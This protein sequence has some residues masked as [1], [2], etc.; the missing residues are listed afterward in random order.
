MDQVSNPLRH[1]HAVSN[2]VV[3]SDILSSEDISSENWRD[4]AA[5]RGRTEEMFPNYHKDI[6]YI[7]N[8]R[9]L[10][11]SCPV[12]NHCE[13]YILQFPMADVSGVWNG[14]TPRQLAA[15]QKRREIKPSKPTIAAMWSE[16]HKG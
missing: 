13:E 3:Q 9:A 7:P 1:I 15:E 14:M 6:T 4:Y 2:P 11:R 16:L 5:C 8:A 10:C 12:G